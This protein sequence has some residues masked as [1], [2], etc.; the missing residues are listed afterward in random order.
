MDCLCS[1]LNDRDACMLKSPCREIHHDAPIC[2]CLQLVPD[3]CT[4]LQKAADQFL[5][6]VSGLLQQRA[7][8]GHGKVFSTY[9]C[10][11]ILPIIAQALGSVVLDPCATNHASRCMIAKESDC[12]TRCK[13]N[14]HINTTRPKL[15]HG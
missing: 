14:A 9:V 2:L 13:M 11:T 15:H 4:K 1:V 7:R 8:K 3:H 5:L 12:M 6:L 10:M